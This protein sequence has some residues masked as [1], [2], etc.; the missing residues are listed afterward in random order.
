MVDEVGVEV[1]REQGTSKPKGSA[2]TFVRTVHTCFV[3]A[4]ARTS[5]N[6]FNTCLRANLKTVDTS[7]SDLQSAITRHVPQIHLQYCVKKKKG[8]ETRCRARKK[9]STSEPVY[10]A[11]C[12]YTCI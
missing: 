2:T 6:T 5:A 3:N 10:T 4:H 7:M 9:R 8:T 1:E 12:L 11:P